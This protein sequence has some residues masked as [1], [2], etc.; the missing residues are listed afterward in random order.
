M[1]NPD[2]PR[3][4]LCSIAR[5]GDHPDALEVAHTIREDT[6]VRPLRPRFERTKHQERSTLHNH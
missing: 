5:T 4:S 1:L 6:S 2:V 3:Q